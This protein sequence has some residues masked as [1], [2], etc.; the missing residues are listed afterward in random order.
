MVSELNVPQKCFFFK[1]TFN[2]NGEGYRFVKC[3]YL[4]TTYCVMLK[5]RPQVSTSLGFM[6]HLLECYDIRFE[7]R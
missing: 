2:K 3:V 6:E 5:V 4:L 7:Y 1:T